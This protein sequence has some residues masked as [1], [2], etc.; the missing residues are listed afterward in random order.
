MCLCFRLC[1][2][3][4]CCHSSFSFSRLFQRCS[5][6][7]CFFSFT[8]LH[9][10]IQFIVLYKI[11]VIVVICNKHMMVVDWRHLSTHLHTSKCAY[12]IYCTHLYLFSFCYSILSHWFL[13]CFTHRLLS[14][15]MLYLLRCTA[16]FSS[17]SFLFHF[18]I[19]NFSIFFM[20]I[21]GL[22][23]L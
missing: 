9:S 10:F 6:T 8:R 5:F 4:Y 16:C 17:F 19:W 1:V 11:I 13:F 23:C 22:I 3:C 21:Y 20:L 14:I 2:S 12:R 18:R 7:L 15:Y